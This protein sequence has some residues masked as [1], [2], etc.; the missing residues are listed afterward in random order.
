MAVRSF[1][2]GWT[3]TLAGLATTAAL[4]ASAVVATSSETVLRNSFTTAL[5]GS[6]TA[7]QQV[8]KSAPVAG[9]GS[10]SSRSNPTAR[11]PCSVN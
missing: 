8:A 6:V 2:S 5:G 3:L 1:L 10:G 11:A 7:G 9:S 4:A